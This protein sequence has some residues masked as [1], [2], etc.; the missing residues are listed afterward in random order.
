V[1]RLAAIAFYP[2]DDCDREMLDL[3]EQVFNQLLGFKGG[4]IFRHKLF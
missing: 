2:E 4:D 3:F 1:S